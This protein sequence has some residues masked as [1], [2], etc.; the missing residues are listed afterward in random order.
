[1]VRALKASSFEP[2][3]PLH[4]LPSQKHGAHIQALKCEV[5][6]DAIIL[7]EGVN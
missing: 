1:M 7:W 4:V 3:P 6:M 2:S 5:G